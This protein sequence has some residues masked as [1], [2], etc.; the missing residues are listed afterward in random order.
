MDTSL[1]KDAELNS[2]PAT[3]AL[4]AGST[5]LGAMAAP[6]TVAACVGYPPMTLIPLTVGVVCGLEASQSRAQQIAAQENHDKK[7]QSPSNE[8]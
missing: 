5:A 2:V 3:V 6:L 7:N 4:K 1:T 8:R